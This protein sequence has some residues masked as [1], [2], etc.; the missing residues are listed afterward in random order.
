MILVCR[1][2]FVLDGSLNVTDSSG[3]TKAELHS[4]DYAFIPAGSDLR[5]VQIS[6]LGEFCLRVPRICV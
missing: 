5:F 6:S 3:W 2:A 4:D 1:F